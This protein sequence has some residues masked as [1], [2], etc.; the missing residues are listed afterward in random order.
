LGSAP[1][2]CRS[3]TLHL[4]FSRSDQTGTVDRNATHARLVHRMLQASRDAHEFRFAAL[5]ESI[6]DL[7]DLVRTCDEHFIEFSAFAA[8]DDL[9]FGEGIDELDHH[10]DAH[11][12]CM[13]EADHLEAGGRSPLAT[14]LVTPLD[15]ERGGYL[16]LL[17]ASA[18]GSAQLGVAVVRM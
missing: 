1:A 16:H 17:D 8:F 7:A 13:D 9:L 5:E 15:G 4:E 3:I 2:D 14:P 11:A 12:M 6:A 18:A 10:E